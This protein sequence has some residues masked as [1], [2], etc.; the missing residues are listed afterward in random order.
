MLLTGWSVKTGLSVPALTKVLA[1]SYKTGQVEISLEKGR[2]GKRKA[3]VN[4]EVES[5]FLQA[6][7]G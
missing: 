6:L 4:G 3:K 5:D 1:A 7:F 2:N